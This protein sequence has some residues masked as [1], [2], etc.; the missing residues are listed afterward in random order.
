MGNQLG[1]PTISAYND[2]KKNYKCFKRF[3]V[4]VQ[5]KMHVAFLQRNHAALGIHWYCHSQ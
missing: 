3:W 2:R 1:E 4:A 5:M